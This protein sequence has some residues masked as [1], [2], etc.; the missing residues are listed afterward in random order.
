L[1]TGHMST[2]VTFG[3]AALSTVSQNDADKAIKLALSHGVNHIDVAPTY[4]D[5]ELRL[6]PWMRKHRDEFFLACK[7]GKRT[8]SEAAEELRRSLERIGVAS[9]D[10]YQLHGLDDLKELDTALGPGGAMEAILEAR[11]QGLA[12]YIGI[13]SHRIPT[14][15]EALTRFDFDTV[16]FPLNHVLRRHRQPY[17]D[18]EPLLETVRKKNI[19][20]I[21]MKAFAKQRWQIEE[22]EYQTW[23]EPFDTQP[24]IDS[25][26]R[27]VL[28]QG[29]TT[30]ASAGDIRLIPKIIS[31]A[32]RYRELSREEQETLI[33]SATNLKPLFP[34]S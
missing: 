8:K 24:E 6:R 30:V 1:R 31:A 20:T 5:A 29:A 14:I 7:T 28:S 25:C 18:Y 13:T 9:F 10:L 15:L 11:D 26:L 23:Y 2:I 33:E 17:N 32:E 4:G 22:H 12:K 34:E 19:G 16:L 21:V 27:F 3:G